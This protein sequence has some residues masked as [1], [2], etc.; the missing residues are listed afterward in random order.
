VLPFAIDHLT[1]AARSNVLLTGYAGTHAYIVRSDI[2]VCGGGYVQV[3]DAV[4]LPYAMWAARAGNNRRIYD[5]MTNGR[6]RIDD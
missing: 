4:L 2:A 6:L 5:E 1:L 3:V